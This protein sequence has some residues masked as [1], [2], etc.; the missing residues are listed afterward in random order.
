MGF[1][2][3]GWLMNWLTGIWVGWLVGCGL[4]GW[5]V[6]N[7]PSLRLSQYVNYVYY[8]DMNMSPMSSQTFLSHISSN[9]VSVLT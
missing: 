5:L 3:A 9:G 8:Q 2:L 1:W 4:A 7:F 6:Y